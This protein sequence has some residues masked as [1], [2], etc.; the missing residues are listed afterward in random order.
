MSHSIGTNAIAISCVDDLNSLRKII[1]PDAPKVSWN[2]WET[3]MRSGGKIITCFNDNTNQV[4]GMLILMPDKNL[5]DIHICETSTLEPGP[6]PIYTALISEAYREIKKSGLT[7][8]LKYIQKHNPVHDNAIIVKNECCLRI[9]GQDFESISDISEAEDLVVV[10]ESYFER[11]I[12][13]IQIDS[14][15]LDTFVQMIEKTLTEQTAF[16]YNFRKCVYG[17]NDLTI[18]TNNR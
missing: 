8:I 3:I 18:I 13:S 9:L 14:V 7:L 16:I 15:E 10:V 17:L 1:M 11:L 2:Y 4:V 5:S 12:K 6:N